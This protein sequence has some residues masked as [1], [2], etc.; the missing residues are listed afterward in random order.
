MDVINSDAE[1]CALIQSLKLSIQHPVLDRALQTLNT[2]EGQ[3]IDF[4]KSDITN[5]R[6]LVNEYPDKTD[7]IMQCAEY[8]RQYAED[9]PTTYKVVDRDGAVLET[10]T[11]TNPIVIETENECVELVKKLQLTISDPILDSVMAVLKADVD[12]DINFGI[13]DN[14]CLIKLAA[15]YPDQANEIN[16]CA[17]YLMECI[18]FGGDMDPKVY[19]EMISAHGVL[20]DLY[21]AA[22]EGTTLNE[23]HG[24]EDSDE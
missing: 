6:A 15:T 23:A 21:T 13:L 22:V 16:A 4:K 20:G 18:D 12:Q 3:D 11:D 14:M 19:L 7:I 24:S 8:L 17:Q 10:L 9:E 2:A 5:L 1:C